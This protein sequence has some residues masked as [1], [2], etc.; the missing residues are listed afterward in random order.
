MDRL[1]EVGLGIA[2]VVVVGDQR[3]SLTGCEVGFDGQGVQE[4]LAFVGPVGPGAGVGEGDGQDE[5]GG[6]QV[7][8]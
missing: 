7:Q 8:A 2:A 6:D 1:G 5:E 3:L 4:G